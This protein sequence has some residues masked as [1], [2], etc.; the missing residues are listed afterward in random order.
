MQ[1]LN[2]LI[3]TSPLFPQ[4]YCSCGFLIYRGAMK[5]R[6]AKNGLLSIANRFEMAVILLTT[7]LTLMLSYCHHDESRQQIEN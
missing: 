4:E 7:M 6:I 5:N 1:R 2:C 3:D